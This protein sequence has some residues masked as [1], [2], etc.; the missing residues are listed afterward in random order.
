MPEDD[1]R[2]DATL[3][4]TL[5]AFG[6]QPL[7]EGTGAPDGAGTDAAGEWYPDDGP[8]GDDGSRPG[9]LVR[10]L[11]WGAA[12][13]GF[14]LFLAALT[15]YG[16]LRD[17]DGTSDAPTPPAV[18]T[19]QV[20]TA[21]APEATVPPTTAVDPPTTLPEAPPEP[22]TT[23]PPVAAE[24]DTAEVTATTAPA[25]RF[26][27]VCGYAPGET[28]EILINGRPAGTATADAD[29]CVSVTR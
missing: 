20:S 22:A 10:W 4:E 23:S 8:A 16:V 9:R 25:P 12:P 14:L 18:A 5:G 28:V 21:P 19:T 17:R 2:D 1:A 15:A 24:T 29:G 6:A 26:G 27:P 3:A 13:L 7:L 11:R